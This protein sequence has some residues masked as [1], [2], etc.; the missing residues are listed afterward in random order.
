MAEFHTSHPSL[1]FAVRRQT[2][3]HKIS[4]MLLGEILLQ[5]MEL[6][7]SAQLLHRLFLP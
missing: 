4:N 3:P 2:D 1:N 6:E 7:P 5:A